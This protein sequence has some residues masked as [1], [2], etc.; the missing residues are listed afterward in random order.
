MN[1]LFASA[2]AFSL[3]ATSSVALSAEPTQADRE[4]WRR[5]AEQRLHEDWAFMSRYREDNAKAVAMAARPRVVFLGDSITQG[6]FDMVPAFFKPGRIGRG[7]SGQTTPQMLVRFRQD[8]IELKPDVVQIMAATNDIAGNTGPMTDE[9]IKNNFRTMV[10]LA[11]AHGIR[12]ILASIPPAA[13]FPWKPGLNPGERVVRLNQW[14]KSYAAQS[15]SIYADYW[16]VLHDG[17]GIKTGLA[18]DGVHPTKEGY[19]VMAP[20]AESAIAA[21]MKLPRPKGLRL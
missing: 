16:G 19:A 4:R 9:A 2:L 15:G 3:L 5:E 21:A 17:L 20:V 7:I 18:S 11:H 12:V 8:V 6:W 14:L 1:T 10:E 13:D